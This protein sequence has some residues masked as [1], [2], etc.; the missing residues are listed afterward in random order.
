MLIRVAE[1]RK[2]YVYIQ[3]VVIS[4]FVLMNIIAL[5][6]IL[7]NCIPVQYDP[8]TEVLRKTRANPIIELLGIRN[9][10]NMV[11]TVSP[12]TSSP[13]FTTHVPLSTSLLIG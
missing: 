6:F 13:T 2:V 11:A 9:Y 7:I 4:M 12:A 3:Y 8:Y 10:L 5:I 1:G